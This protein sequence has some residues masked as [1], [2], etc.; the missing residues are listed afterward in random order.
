M[1]AR[2]PTGREPALVEVG[3]GTY[4]AEWRVKRLRFLF[5]DGRTADVLTAHDNSDLRGALLRTLGAERIEGS[6]E[7]IG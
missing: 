3:D 6:T 4:A 1:S 7:I 2:T 5:S